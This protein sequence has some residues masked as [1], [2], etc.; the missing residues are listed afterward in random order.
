MPRTPVHPGR[1]SW[2][3][4]NPFIYMKQPQGDDWAA[5]C[6]FFRINVSAHGIGHAFLV[7]R[8]PDGTGDSG[9]MVPANLC[10]TDNE[11]LARYLLN[12][13]VSHFGLFRNRPGLAKVQYLAME[14]NDR[15]GDGLQ[16]YTERGWGNGVYVAMTWSD[17]QTPFAAELDNAHTATGEHEMF[18]VF[19]EARGAEVTVN[20]EAVAGRLFPR[21]FLGAERYSASLVFSET[22]VEAPTGSE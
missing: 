6:L 22:W 13:F 20:G 1:V 11:P 21:D 19:V 5:L 18:S 12:D 4:E 2:S 3:G 9:G 15:S 14:G 16:Q 8:D 10:L 7:V 17:L